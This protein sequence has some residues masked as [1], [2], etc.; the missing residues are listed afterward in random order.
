MNIF[1]EFVLHGIQNKETIL[2]L[3]ALEDCLYP[4]LLARIL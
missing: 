4:L 3:I 1:D 2:D